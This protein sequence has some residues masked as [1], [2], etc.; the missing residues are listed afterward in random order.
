STE[1]LSAGIGTTGF[2]TN[3]SGGGTA[4]SGVWFSCD[5]DGGNGRDYRAWKTNS[6]L[7]A[8]SN[9]G[10]YSAPP[11]NQQAVANPYYA[12]FGDDPAPLAQQ[13]AFPNDQ[14]GNTGPGNAGFAWHDVMITKQGNSVTWA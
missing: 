12:S 7:Q 9:P 10:V 11:P 3:W 5:G 1:W 4:I 8:S 2:T 13:L 14:I 6:E